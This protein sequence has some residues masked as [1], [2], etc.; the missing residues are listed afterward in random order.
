MVPIGW[1]S[2]SK[3]ERRLSWVVLLLLFFLQTN[4]LIVITITIFI[5][6]GW[7]GW[8]RLGQALFESFNPVCCFVSSVSSRRASP[9]LRERLPLPGWGSR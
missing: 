7:A 6:I 8:A 9:F 2:I 3:V 5:G 1:A 4:K